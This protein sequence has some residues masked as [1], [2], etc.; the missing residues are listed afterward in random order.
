[1]KQLRLIVRPNNATLIGFKLYQVGKDDFSGLYAACGYSWRRF[2]VAVSSVKSEDFGEPQRAEFGPVVAALTARGC[3]TEL[4]PIE[5]FRRPDRRWYSK[6]RRRVVAVRAQARR[7]E[8]AEAW[9]RKRA[10]EAA[11]QEPAVHGE[12]RRSDR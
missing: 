10:M 12:R 2:L 9:K 4:S 11:E 8:W 5:P 6:Q 7:H 3:P 1:V